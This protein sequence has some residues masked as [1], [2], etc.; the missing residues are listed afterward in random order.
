MRCVRLAREH[1]ALVKQI[2]ETINAF[3]EPCE[4]ERV[5]EL[6]GLKRCKSR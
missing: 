3:K 6:K 5:R 1:E 2:E 4:E